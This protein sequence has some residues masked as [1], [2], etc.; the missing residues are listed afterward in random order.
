MTPIFLLHCGKVVVIEENSQHPILF[1]EM[2]YIIFTSSQWLIFNYQ[3]IPSEVSLCNFWYK[4]K[5]YL[6]NCHMTVIQLDNMTV[7]RIE[8]LD[9]CNWKERVPPNSHV[10]TRLERAIRKQT[11]H[12]L[13]SH[14]QMTPFSHFNNYFIV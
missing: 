13:F 4:I 14:L 8:T 11:L 6:I 9:S 12:S 3:T 2:Q 10:K 7:Q 1:I 5:F